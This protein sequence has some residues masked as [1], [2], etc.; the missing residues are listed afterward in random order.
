MKIIELLILR[1]L[2]YKNYVLKKLAT[3]KKLLFLFSFS[4]LNMS[5]SRSL[6]EYVISAGLSRAVWHV[7]Q[8]VNY[9]RRIFTR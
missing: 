9:W 6:S 3:C 8:H 7:L 1:I 2:N 4:S 5:I